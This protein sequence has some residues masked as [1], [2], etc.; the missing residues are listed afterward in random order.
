[1]VNEM[2]M[3]HWPDI[4]TWILKSGRGRQEKTEKGQCEDTGFEVEEGA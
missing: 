4:I 1:M 2:K 3:V